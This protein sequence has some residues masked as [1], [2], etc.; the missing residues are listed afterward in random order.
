MPCWHR[1]RR[2]NV[3]LYHRYSCVFPLW[4]VPCGPARSPFI[5]PTPFGRH[6]ARGYVPKS[7]TPRSPPPRL[8]SRL[9]L[10]QRLVISGGGRAARAAFVTC[11]GSLVVVLPPILSAA[12]PPSTSA[13]PHPHPPSNR[14]LLDLAPL[15]TLGWARDERSSCV[16]L[17][18]S[19]P[20]APPPPN[21]QWRQHT[22]CV[23]QRRAK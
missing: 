6:I 9:T 3:T 16:Q 4:S 10:C 14:L 13:R 18:Q 1:L 20:R 2:M 8:F 7:S 5:A 11:G 17:M 21:P 23:H 15:M 19:S 22:Q 12:P